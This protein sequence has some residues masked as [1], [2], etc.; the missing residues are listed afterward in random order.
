MFL[1]VTLIFD[2]W[3]THLAPRVESSHPDTETPLLI[4]IEDRHYIKEP[5]TKMDE[6]TTTCCDKKQIFGV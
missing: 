4:Y 3:F 6:D 5:L 1:V 2:R